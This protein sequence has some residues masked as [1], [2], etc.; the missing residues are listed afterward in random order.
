[1]AGYRLAWFSTGRDK[2]ARDL[3]QAV[4]DA[5]K[6]GNINAEIALVFSNREPGEAEESNRFFKL[7]AGL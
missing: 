4:T 7:A 3:L 1:M 6:N 5:I 2:A